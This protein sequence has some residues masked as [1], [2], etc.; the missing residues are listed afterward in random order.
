[1]GLDHI[2]DD[3]AIATEVFGPDAASLDH[4]SWQ[5]ITAET[6]FVLQVASSRRRPVSQRLHRW[7]VHIIYS[8]K[9]DGED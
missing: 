6:E 1:M 7:M 5:L 3:M 8:S 2:R 4:R 9:I